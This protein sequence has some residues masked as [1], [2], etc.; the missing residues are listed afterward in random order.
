[1]RRALPEAL[2]AAMLTAVLAVPIFGLRI[3][4]HHLG[5]AFGMDALVKQAD[6]I[7]VLVL[8]GGSKDDLPHQSPELAA[9]FNLVDSFDTHAH[10]P[11]HFAAVDLQLNAQIE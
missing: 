6:K 8:C 5:G 2:L 7:D 1:M 11:E 10:I 3:H 4:P 9:R